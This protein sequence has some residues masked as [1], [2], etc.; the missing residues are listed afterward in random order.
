MKRMILVLLV[1]LLAGCNLPTGNPGSGVGSPSEAGSPVS[2]AT[3]RPTFILRPSATPYAAN[4]NQ[5]GLPTGAQGT[6]SILVHPQDENFWYVI[7]VKSSAG[8]ENGLFVTHNAG[9]TWE[10]LYSAKLMRVIAIDPANPERLFTSDYGK[11]LLS[12]DRGQNW[13][14]LHDFDNLIISIHISPRDGAIYVLPSWYTSTDPGLYRSDDGGR[15]WVFYS[16][17]A[18]MLNFIPWDIEEDPNTGTLYVVIELADHPQ[19]YDP[20]FYRSLDRGE[21]WEEIGDDLRWHG[22][23]IQVDPL[24]SDVYYLAEGAGLFKSTDMGNHWARISPQLTFAS[25][26]VLDPARPQRLIGGDLLNLPL[27]EGGVFYSDDGGEN[28][29]FLGLKGH[30]ISDIALNASSTRMYVVSRDE[31]IFTAVIPAPMQ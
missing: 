15:S 5:V 21:S 27:Y 10:T 6:N 2:T 11:L 7:G 13:E 16:Y 30:C 28:F 8:S 31:G 26:L 20:P 22:L 17:G 24:T 14:S 19:P 12:T 9:Q 23:S 1:V 25:E 3:A 29:T 4:W 18:G